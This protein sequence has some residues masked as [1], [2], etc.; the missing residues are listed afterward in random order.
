VLEYRLTARIELE[1]FDA[2]LLPTTTDHPTI[3]EIAADSIGVNARL[4][5]FSNFVNLLDMCAVSIPAGDADGGPFGV[6]VVAAAFHDQV[7]V[8][9]AAMIVDVETPAMTY[10]VGAMP[11]VLQTRLWEVAASSVHGNRRWLLWL[12]GDQKGTKTM[13]TMQCMM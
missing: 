9:I 11:L 2:L 4:G 3:A 6:T 13:Q 10:P 8:D 5:T 7:A 12:V 1:G